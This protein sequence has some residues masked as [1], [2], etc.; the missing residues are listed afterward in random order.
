[1]NKVSLDVWIQLIGMVGILGGLLFVG[2]EM[3][4]TQRI[5]LANQQQSRTELITDMM[6]V[7]MELVGEFEVGN[8]QLAADWE[9]MTPQQK[10]LRELRQSYLWQVL[11]NN[12]FQNEMGLLTPDLWEQVE[13]YNIARWSEC[14]LRHTFNKSTRYQPFAE[15]LE[16]LPDN[17]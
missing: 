11:E 9:R 12:Y 13:R 3:Q 14:H 16:T 1:M 8:Q 5:A 15:Y 17:C 7:Q 6:L 2:L 4:Q 10:S